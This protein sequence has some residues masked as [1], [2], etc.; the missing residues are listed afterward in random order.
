M[1]LTSQNNVQNL[2]YP[3]GLGRLTAAGHHYMMIDSYESRTALE[4]VG[5][6]KSSIAL[7]LSLIHI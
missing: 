4:T 7:Y 5:T 1:R 6:R 3:V 2:E